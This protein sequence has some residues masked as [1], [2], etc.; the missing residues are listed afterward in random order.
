M[1]EDVNEMKNII[2]SMA[3][4]LNVLEESMGCNL[5][6][7]NGQTARP[8][9][10]SGAALSD[11]YIENVDAGTNGALLKVGDED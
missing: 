2:N 3:L 9:Q 1:H 4:F 6:D 8:R 5:P 11:D 10:S 7:R